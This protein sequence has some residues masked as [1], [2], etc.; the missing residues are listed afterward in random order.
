MK[1]THRCYIL[2][3]TPVVGVRLNMTAIA[4]NTTLTRLTI[5]CGLDLQSLSAEDLPQEQINRIY[6]LPTNASII[7]VLTN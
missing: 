7:V 2:Y 1:S 6:E 4:S 3:S 5:T